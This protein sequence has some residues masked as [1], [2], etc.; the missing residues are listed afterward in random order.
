[1]SKI[2]KYEIDKYKKYFSE[3]ALWEKL[4]KYAKVV[5]RELVENVLILWYAFPEAS[6][7]E[8]AIIMG[9]VGYFI[10]PI[11]A[12]PDF[13]PVLGYT[14]DAAVVLAVVAKIRLSASP[15]VIEKA[16]NKTEEYFKKYFD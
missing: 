14:D 9:A 8:K 16:K 2:D 4:V 7:K 13:T 11:D 10:A 5:G 1:M 3:E 6:A 15:S 12:I